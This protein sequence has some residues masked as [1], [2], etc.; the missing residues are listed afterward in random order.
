MSF[1]AYVLLAI[2][3]VGH[4]LIGVG[5]VNR[6]HGIPLRKPWFKIIE[7][8]IF[9]WTGFWALAAAWSV[10]SGQWDE[11]I[12]ARGR[13]EDQLTPYV[14]GYFAFAAAVLL[15]RFPAWWRHR[16]RE[17]PPALVS[18]R[19]ACEDLSERIG[20]RPT[21]RPLARWL[22]RLPFNE[23]FHLEVRHK[24]LRLERLP[25]A[26]AGFRIGHLSDIHLSGRIGIEYFEA[27][28]E[29]VNREAPDIWMV[30]GDL[31]DKVACLEWLPSTLAR[32]RAPLGVCF[33]LGNHD[34]RLPDL[35]GVRKRLTDLGWL[36][37]GG[38][39]ECVW[40]RDTPVWLAGNERPW[41]KPFP[42]WP[43][44]PTEDEPEAATAFRLALLH[45]PD[46]F[47]W[48]WQRDFDL[49]LAGH[50]HGGQVRLPGIGPL[51][52]PSLYGVKY[53]GGVFQ[54]GRTVMH[55]SR[56]I[57]GLEP[58]RW[59]CPPEAAILTLRSAVTA[60]DGET[61]AAV[62]LGHSPRRA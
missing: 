18:D 24:E 48:A 14:A 9:A 51:V 22:A 6:L 8:P 49:V 16:R 11:W 32:L 61:I 23:I 36:D 38:R 54:E 62:E 34:W 42:A 45:T 35:P 44:T 29:R 17:A 55:V 3:L 30:T 53:A 41:F 26:L 59:S 52:S 5:A 57:S 33:I 21:G 7:L 50:T 56:G 1:V 46:Q 15:I 40:W 47:A 19:G 31:F 27:V 25:A 10:A 58:I 39:A 12:A 4:F 13:I 60:S 43:P 20:G 37:L 28:V 2:G